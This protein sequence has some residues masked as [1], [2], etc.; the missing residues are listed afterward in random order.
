M[1]T[2]HLDYETRSRANLKTVGAHRY[3]IDP[4][5]EI[6]MASVSRDEE[7]ETYLWV[8][9]KFRTPD[10]LGDNEEAER[11]LAEAD[12]IYAHNV[13]FEQACTWG[14]ETQGKTRPL[15]HDD[16]T[17]WRCTAAMARRAGLPWSLDK[18]GEALRLP[19]QKDRR[20]KALI[21][22][23]CVPREDG[24]FNEPRDFPAEWRE[25]GDY[26]ITDNRV[27]KGAHHKLKPFELTGALLD[28]FQFDLR[29]NQRG[30]PINVAAARNAQKI[31]DE[32]QAGAAVE[33]REL[34]GLNPTQGEKFKDWLSA[35]AF[36]VPNLQAE[37]VSDI[38][39]GP[40][41]PAKIKQVLTLYQSLSYAAVKKIQTMLDCV[42]PDGRVRGGHLF[43]GA[44][45][46]RWSGKLLQPQ[47]FKKTPVEMK[48]MTDGVYDAVCKG[49]DAV[50]IDAVYGSP[51][52][53]LSI[54]I[55]HFIHLPGV[56]I[57]DG[58]YNA[59][60]ARIVCWLAG[61]ETALDE[62]RKDIDRYQLM[63]VDIYERELE[64][65]KSLGKDSTERTVGK[66]TVLGC[67]FGL[68]RP[69][70]FQDTVLKLS[71]KIISEKLAARCI[72]IY[73][74]KHP[75][76]VAYWYQMGEL[77]MNAVRNPRIPSGPFSIRVVAG[78]PF[79]LF[80][81]R[82]GRSLAY[83]YPKIE[84]FPFTP[85][86]PNEDMTDEEWKEITEARGP[87]FR[88]NVT[89]WGQLPMSQQWGRI[90][91]WPGM[92]VE[93]ETQAS[94]MDLMAHGAIAAEKAGMEPFMLV[95]DQGLALR[96]NGQTP[97]QY[98]KALGA[99]PN[100]AK[101]LPLKVEAKLTKYYRK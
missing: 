39:A 53:M 78:I 38:L 21:N 54:C 95:H 91:L 31:V 72:K 51:L 36:P 22:F 82:S 80:R 25:F 26:C 69:K 68:G 92:I 83:P 4:S 59:V 40:E 47:N 101:T 1:K 37:T 75:K 94:A 5:F 77:C 49:A 2:C 61:E 56:E 98:E 23:F 65:I 74:K 99:L 10:M 11:I 55:R 97:E 35:Q 43:Y 96:T 63:A 48:D 46:G 52:E 24:Q 16:L 86:K 45:T 73:R 15:A 27:E 67:G 20:G 88:E 66:H 62:Y 41:V 89:Y 60:E 58:D 14:A 50:A 28:T 34:V 87:Q 44:G 70:R 33:F 79:L 93:N 81:L 100:W 32:M 64:Y 7:D 9:P 18:L 13:Y 42:C 90:K 71:G 8:N 19:V 76:V 30:I 57:L 84:L 6:L 12:Q 17:K 29:M 3:A 85:N